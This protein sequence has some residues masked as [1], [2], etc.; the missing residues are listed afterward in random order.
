MTTKAELAERE[1]ARD[2]LREML[3]PGDT[4]YTVLR[5]VSRS[6][7]SREITM[8]VIEDGEPWWISGYAARAAGNRLGPRDG[9]VVSGCGMDMGFALVYELSRALYPDGFGCI[10]KGCPANDHVNPGDRRDDYSPD[11]WHRE[12]GYAL[13][14][15]WL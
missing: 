8:H 14:H 13:R 12:G 3:N 5:H 2:R 7:M 6:G 11:H 15:R 1:E 9:V 4:V 10:G